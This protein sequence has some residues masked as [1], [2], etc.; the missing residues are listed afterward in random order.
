MIRP[1]VRGT[2]GLF[3]GGDCGK[4]VDCGSP[5]R[6]GQ[7]FAPGHPVLQDRTETKV[8]RGYHY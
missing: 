1:E 4:N 5:S 7:L 8:R 6:Q 2:A 3:S